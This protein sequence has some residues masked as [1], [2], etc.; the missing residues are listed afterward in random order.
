M[1]FVFYFIVDIVS[2]KKDRS[3]GNLAKITGED[4]NKHSTNGKSCGGGFEHSDFGANEST[5][6]FA[7]WDLQ[8]E[9]MK[10]QQCNCPAG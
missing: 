5:P 1:S 9:M 6:R 3:N 4:F 2:A 7:D 8:T 10:V